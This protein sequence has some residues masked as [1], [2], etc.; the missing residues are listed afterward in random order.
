MNSSG[1]QLHRRWSRRTR[2]IAANSVAVLVGS[3]I[4][5]TPG[6]ATSAPN[7]NA[8]EELRALRAD[9]ADTASGVDVSELDKPLEQAEKA[10]AN[11]ADC[12]VASALTD[13]ATATNE[14]ANLPAV[15]LERLA[16]L[17]ERIRGQVLNAVLAGCAGP[18]TIYVDPERSAPKVASLPGYD[19]K[20]PRT[21][22][23]MI[24]SDGV[25]STF[26]ADE[27]LVST[28][29]EQRLKEFLERWRG[30]V[31]SSFVPPVKAAAT[32]Y[33][34]RVVTELADPA[35]LSE[36]LAK[37]NDG[38]TKADTL[39][40]SSQAALRLLAIAA[41]EAT[42]DGN[43]LTIGVNWITDPTSYADRSLMEAGAGPAG[44][45]NDELSAY[46]RNP[47]DWSY[48]NAGSVQD[49]GVTEAWRMLDS[50]DQLDNKVKIAVLDTGFSPVINGD[51]PT[52]FDGI[53]MVPG[54]D[55]GDIGTPSGP[56]H[57][58][59]VA[60]AAAAVPGNFKGAAGPAG[61][62][63]DL[64]FFY[65]GEDMFAAMAGLGAAV[66][67]GNN[68]INMSIGQ[69][70]HWALSW[71]M[72][73]WDGLT[74]LLRGFANVL[75]FAAAGNSGENIDH[76]DCA[77]WGSCWET[78]FYAPCEN[79]GVICVGGLGYNTR[80]RAPRSNYGAEHVDVFAP[81]NV[82]V[83][84][85]PLHPDQSEARM[86][87]G[88]SYASPYA[89]G[90]AA[91]IWAANP[92]LSND[93]VE[94][95]LTSRLRLSPDPLVNNRVISAYTA[96]LDAL[97]ASI[98]IT[99]PMDGWVLSAVTPTQFAATV[100]ADGNGSPTVTW[101]L[102]NGNL[103]GTGNP[104]SALPPPGTHTIT[105]RLTFPNGVTASDAITVSVV[106][107]APTL[108]ITNPGPGSPTFGVSDPI[109]FHALSTDDAG[110]LVDSRLRWFLN[111]STVH[112]ATGH[113]PTV[114]TGGGVGT[115]TVRLRACDSFYIC[116]EDSVVIT[117]AANT[118]NQPPVVDILS[119]A[120]GTQ[121][122]V[123][124][125]DAAG[126]YREIALNA[127]AVDPE[128]G[129]L[130]TRWLDDGVQIATGLTPTV[131][132]RGGCG[133]WSHTLTFIATDSVGNSRQDSVQVKVDLIC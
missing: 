71:T 96:V 50:V 108:T 129:V 6:T 29:D 7:L 24:N 76:T 59:E 121:L 32:H 53:S 2:M 94:S 61:P 109:P 85:D 17:G 74:E 78:Y 118:S 86:V 25:R 65:I 98:N 64:D 79:N 101:R 13:F 132:L 120:N 93:S 107:H 63:A 58:T 123:N 100:Y 44:F 95:L 84:A 69:R 26:V 22:A 106:N 114:V 30:T 115:H 16:R 19:P 4:V 28:A 119:P 91:L 34:V 46:S 37:L 125:S 116:V 133:S 5:A 126:S 66:A 51:L 33:L 3:L 47:Y 131:R 49:I 11:G 67:R 68:L 112:F 99:T 83:G 81:Y 57:G 45:N 75:I 130:T 72:I 97:E 31:L 92:S 52:G 1:T 80:E 103:L 55:I 38:R 113:N 104:I 36:Q 56:W 102:A 42:T 60:S 23:G 127:T 90:V 18:V 77:F 41:Q 111:G 124:G 12:T 39:A 70:I 14:D 10:A 105:A 122:W 82:L 88:T 20:T 40:V 110:P 8:V 54:A 43:P 89:A 73:P 128:G 27:V 62:I 87:H 21:V 15:E 48:L 117:L 9:L 35:P